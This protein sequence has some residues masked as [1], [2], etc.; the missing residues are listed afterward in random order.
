[1]WETLPAY[2]AG[3]L[4]VEE[5]KWISQ[6][7]N[8]S[9]SAVITIFMGWIMYWGPRWA[10]AERKSRE[11]AAQEYSKAMDKVLE[12]SNEQSRYEREE[13]NRRNTD[14]LDTVKVLI[15]KLEENS[16][17]LHEVRHEA[18]NLAQV[19]INQQRLLEMLGYPV[20]AKKRPK[21]ET[22]L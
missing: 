10:D 21:D 5:L 13:C 12:N 17:V 2:I 15:Q 19:V 22:N 3:V 4:T 18:V 6:F 8:L 16:K 7:S 1:M 11:K 20:A 9:S 14:T